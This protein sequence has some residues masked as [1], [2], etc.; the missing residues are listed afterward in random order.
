LHRV[1]VEH[2][3][4]TM[5][6]RLRHHYLLMP[7]NEL[8]LEKV[9]GKSIS[10]V[11]VLLRHALIA[12]GHPIIPQSKRD[13]LSAVAQV[14]GIEPAALHAVLDLREGR[15]AQAGIATLYQGYMECVAQMVSQVDQIAVK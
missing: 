11:M 3:L 9:L 4:R 13:I 2:E 7:G 15:R 5:L 8:E 6:L 1:Q 14:F 10:S 12:V